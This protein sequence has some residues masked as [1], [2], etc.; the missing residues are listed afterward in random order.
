LADDI[1]ETVDS[2]DVDARCAFVRQ[3]LSEHAACSDQLRQWAEAW[4]SSWADGDCSAVK[5]S[6]ALRGLW[7]QL[8]SAWVEHAASEE[9]RLAKGKPKAG[10]G[11]R[12]GL[13]A[14]QGGSAL[15]GVLAASVKQLTETF[16][17]AADRSNAT[18]AQVASALGAAAP[19]QATGSACCTTSGS[20]QVNN[21]VTAMRE[22]LEFLRSYAGVQPA[23]SHPETLA[24]VHK[25]LGLD[26][27]LLQDGTLLEKVARCHAAAQAQI[28]T[29]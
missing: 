20:E 9:A 21:R 27:S 18:L 24:A 19:V 29:E 17:A 15:A 25:A 4:I 3:Q 14:A 1:L 8:Q 12:G 16:T 13:E 28:Q 26:Q 23:A 10:K 11:A 7:A 5:L 2:K 6:S 22:Q